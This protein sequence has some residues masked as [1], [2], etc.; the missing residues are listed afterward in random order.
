LNELAE[1]PIADTVA[2]LAYHHDQFKATSEGLLR[3]SVADF[4]FNYK[5]AIQ[6]PLQFGTYSLT[7]SAQELNALFNPLVVAFNQ[8]VAAFTRYLMDSLQE[9][10]PN[11]NHWYQLWRHNQSFLSDG[12]VTVRGISGV[13]STVNTTT[14]SYFDAT[15]AVSLNQFLQNLGISSSSGTPDSELS[16]AL[17]RQWAAKLI[18]ALTPTPTTARVG[19]M[20]NLDI[21]PHALAGASSAELAIT[22]TVADDSSPSLYS[23]GTGAAAGN[24]DLLSHV[25]THNVTSRVRVESIKLFDISSFS[26]M[27][28]RPRSKFPL[29]PPFVEIPFVG[30]LFGVPLPVAREYHRSTA[31]VSAIIVPTAADLAYGIVFSPDQGAIESQKAMYGNWT[32]KLKPFSSPDQLRGVP[33][34]AFHR[35]MIDCL[36]RPAPDQ[37]KEDCSSLKFG[38]VPPEY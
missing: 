1:T 9:E 10:S 23:S 27:V 16:S 20:L 30:T 25:A 7:H 14:Q 21:T 37:S 34:S 4:L 12:L 31:I 13:D 36:A 18:T 24:N 29:L 32:F 11:Q 17:T 19:K 38:T 26:A 5:M 6:Y 22:L 15:Q 35:K 3:S 33:V 8:D 2:P 28:Q